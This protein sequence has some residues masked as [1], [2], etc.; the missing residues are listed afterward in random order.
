MPGQRKVASKDRRKRVNTRSKLISA[1][2]DMFSELGSTHISIDQICQ[3]AGF[4]RGAFYSNFSSV[5]ELF[6]AVYERKTE[7]VLEGLS[8]AGFEE[9]PKLT[10]EDAAA[11]LVQIIPEDTQWYALRASFATRSRSNPEIASTL[12]QH[13][14]QFRVGFTPVLELAVARSGMM[15]RESPENASRILIAA[16]VG[17]VLQAPLVDGPEALRYDTV[18]AIL[19]GL[20][21]AQ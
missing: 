14:E 3:R 13:A 8:S 2:E 18:L 7:Q 17:A 20:T 19:R 9:A 21:T 12:H 1:A 10:L 11:V 16:N 15:L 4:T 5:E 6:F